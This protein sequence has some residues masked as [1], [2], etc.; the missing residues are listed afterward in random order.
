MF[1]IIKAMFEIFYYSNLREKELVIRDPANLFEISL[2]RQ[3]YQAFHVTYILEALVDVMEYLCAMPKGDF[4]TV[5]F[6]IFKRFDVQ[7]RTKTRL[8]AD[9]HLQHSVLKHDL[10]T[11]MR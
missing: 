10:G 8:V 3:Y 9:G 1:I 6:K 7:G 2:K 5:D 4:V 11:V